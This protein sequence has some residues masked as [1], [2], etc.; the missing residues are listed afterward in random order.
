MEFQP[1]DYNAHNNEMTNSE[2]DLQEQSET[3]YG[4]YFSKGIC[5]SFLQYN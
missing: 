3:I 2:R 4:V 1:R 5:S